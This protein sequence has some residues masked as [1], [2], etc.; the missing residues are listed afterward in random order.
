MC[1][2]PAERIRN[3]SPGPGPALP[4]PVPES[5]LELPQVPPT[6]CPFQEGLL[7][8]MSSLGYVG[9]GLELSPR[10][11]TEFLF[12]SEWDSLPE[13]LTSLSLFL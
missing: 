9:S 5:S 2:L 10:F 11:L 1:F 13:C 4:G 7:G 12:D 3:S 8:R 6:P